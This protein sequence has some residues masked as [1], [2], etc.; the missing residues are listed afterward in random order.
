M[1]RADINDI[2]G[3]TP[4]EYSLQGRETIPPLLNASGKYIEAFEQFASVVERDILRQDWEHMFT[5]TD[6]SCNLGEWI[7]NVNRYWKPMFDKFNTVRAVSK[8]ISL[9]INR[10]RFKQPHGMI[11][12]SFIV[13]AYIL[14]DQSDRLTDTGLKLSRHQTELWFTYKNSKFA[15]VSALQSF[16]EVRN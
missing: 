7:E 12:G 13:V 11:L 6:R 5:F 16:V 1:Y 9:D 3:T 10:E 4:D 2:L 8:N 15:I 14:E